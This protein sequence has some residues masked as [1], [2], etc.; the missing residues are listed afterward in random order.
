LSAF[1][2]V[3]CRSAAIDRAPLKSAMR[4]DVR[5]HAA[6]MSRRIEVAGLPAPR[7][8]LGALIHVQTDAFNRQHRTIGISEIGR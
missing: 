4:E 1:N 7:R 5:Y 6:I 8:S 2:S 3:V